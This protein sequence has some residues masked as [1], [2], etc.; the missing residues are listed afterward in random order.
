[1]KEIK[2]LSQYFLFLLL[3]VSF[4]FAYLVFKP[5]ISTVV[6]GGV[7]ASL[8]YP[9]YRFFRRTFGGNETVAAL[10]TVLVFIAIIVIPLGNFII[11]L[12][13]ESSQTYQL[14]QQKVHAG[15]G[16]GQAFQQW[17]GST[18]ALIERYLPFV[19]VSQFDF[20]Q[21]VLDLGGNINSFLVSATTVLI[22]ST[23]QFITSLFFM[24]LTMFFLFKDGKK[25]M[26]RVSFLTPLPNKYDK[27]LFDKFQQITRTTIMS[28]LVI[29]VVQ[30]ALSAIAYA[31]I[32]LPALFLGFSTAIAALVPIVGTTVVWVPAAI[33]LFIT[34]QWW[35]FIF[36]V[37]W[38]V[39]FVTTS[40]N[41]IRAYFIHEQA[42]IH[43]LL[44][45]F[46]VLGGVAA[47]GVPGIIFGP[48]ILSILLTVI[49]IYELE[50][51]HILER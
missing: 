18:Q 39:L 35:Q 22:R 23:T 20:N 49:H 11:L 24:L 19:D 1:M 41:I 29:A 5:F 16:A 15:N 8:L 33:Y 40:D 26:D 38:G 6:L 37:A 10:V 50:Y 27:K 12:A 14:L 28:S 7:F 13:K 31:I 30:G 44:V 48:L 21:I 46:S 4:F 25:L 47:F 32:G 3:A 42:N 17:F 9:V 43:P 34:G 36:L 45:F 2:N 51:E